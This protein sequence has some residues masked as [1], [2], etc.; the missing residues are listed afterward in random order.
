MSI[1]FMCLS[2]WVCVCYVCLRFSTRAFVRRSTTTKYH[3]YAFKMS[4]SYC[5]RGLKKVGLGA[6]L[7][8]LLIADIAFH[9]AQ[10]VT[11]EN[12]LGNYLFCCVFGWELLV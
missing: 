10:Q 8:L 1:V 6:F 12:V 2:A 5:L 9:I 11:A 4:L 3:H 7:S